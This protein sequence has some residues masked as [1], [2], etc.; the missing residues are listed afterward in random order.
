[1]VGNYTQLYDAGETSEVAIDLIV[2]VGVA[3][4][5]FAS[6]VGLILLYNWVKKRMK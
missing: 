5:S 1:M 4:V 6:L 3:L 2:G